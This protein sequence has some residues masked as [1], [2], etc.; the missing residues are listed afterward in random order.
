MAANIKYFLPQP[1]PPVKFEPLYLQEPQDSDN[2]FFR[3]EELR[4]AMIRN[5]NIP[6]EIQKGGPYTRYTGNSYADRLMK[7]QL[8]QK[9]VL[10]RQKEE[11]ANTKWQAIIDAEIVT[12]V[13]EA[14]KKEM[15][16][17]NK[18]AMSTPKWGTKTAWSS[19]VLLERQ[20]SILTYSC[21][22]EA[23]FN[24]IA[25]I[26]TRALNKATPITEIEFGANFGSPID[27]KKN[28][29]TISIQIR[30]P[31]TLHV[32]LIRAVTDGKLRWFT[33]VSYNENTTFVATNKLIDA[34]KLSGEVKPNSVG[35]P[36]QEKRRRKVCL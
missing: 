23:M 5:C 30:K 4:D 31:I 10:M 7:M 36:K 20:K 3:Y 27:E 2:G 1:P 25:D 18:L 32:D 13:E 29:Q 8:E 12:R 34:S 21:E 14:Q 26:V 16:L 22:M 19:D 6:S 28:R 33:E 11:E 15:E 24:V 9:A 17:P 35:E